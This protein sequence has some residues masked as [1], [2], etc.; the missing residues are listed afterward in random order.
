MK[1]ESNGK[2]A[3]QLAKEPRDKEDDELSEE[4]L[5]QMMIIVPVQG[6][7][8]EAFQTKEWNKHLH[9]GREGVSIV[10]RNSYIDAG[11]KAL[12]GLG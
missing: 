3:V 12:G 10:K 1:A 9:A 8:V 4:D 7:N 6:M 5:Q 11:S 2:E